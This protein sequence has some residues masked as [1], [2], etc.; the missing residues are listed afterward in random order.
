MLDLP[1]KFPELHK[2]LGF[3]EREIEALL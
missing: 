2:F 1:P 3:G